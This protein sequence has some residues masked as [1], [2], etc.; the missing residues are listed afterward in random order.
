[1][2][3]H[4]NPQ[5]IFVVPNHSICNASL[6]V[7]FDYLPDEYQ[8]DVIFVIFGEVKCQNYMF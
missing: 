6:S 7:H 3:F 2:S 8:M 5:E 1:M 4:Q